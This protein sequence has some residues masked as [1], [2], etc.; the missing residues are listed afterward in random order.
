MLTKP[1]PTP[2]SQYSEGTELK[3]LPTTSLDGQVSPKIPLKAKVKH[4]NVGFGKLQ[5]VVECTVTELLGHPELS[6]GTDVIALNF[7]Q[8]YMSIFDLNPV[9]QNT[10]SL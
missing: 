9:P 3:L 6:L 5:Q 7:D 1:F 8:L 10:I 2:S 4:I